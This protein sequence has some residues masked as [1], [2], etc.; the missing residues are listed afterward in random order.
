ML[1]GWR[2]SGTEEVLDDQIDRESD[3]R[4]RASTGAHECSVALRRKLSDHLVGGAASAI[5]V[6]GARVG[7][8]CGDVADLRR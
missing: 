7:V 4:T 6:L 2:K 8:W 3:R 5:F 1:V